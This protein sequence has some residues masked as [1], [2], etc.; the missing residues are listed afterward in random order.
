MPSKIIVKILAIIT[1]F[2]AVLYIGYLVREELIWIITAFSLSLAL[3]PLVIFIA[4]YMPSKREGVRRGLSIG[5]VFVGLIAVIA[6][7]IALFIPPLI[8]Q[9]QTFI[10]NIPSY[11]D[12]LLAPNSFTG[13]II[14]KYNLM[15]RVR[16][17]QGQLGTY[18]SQVGGSALGILKAI[19]SSAIATG[20]IL[21][22]TIFMLNEGP[23][24]RRRAW[25]LVGSAHEQRYQA[26]A[27]DMYRSVTAYVNGK[28]LMSLLAAVPTT[29]IL[30]ILNVPY[31]IA[32]GILVGLVDLIPLV[33]ATLGAVAVLA[34]CAFTSLTAVI[35]MAIFFIVYQ[36]VENHIFQPIIFGKSVEISSLIVLISILFGARI[37]GILGALIAIP[38]TASLQ[39][40]FK[41]YLKNRQLTK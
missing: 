19:F 37:G 25:A 33:G 12:Q 38:V 11:Y 7:L 39:I 14:R 30:A 3:N 4:K 23:T 16:S 9:T 29:V 41:D 2:L 8:S 22:F 36:Q 21:V 20:S 27:S 34:V 35:V 24:W 31:A 1:G 5:V 17:S 15:D 13:D 10:H 32:L 26:L 6:L 18:A 28:L 40:L